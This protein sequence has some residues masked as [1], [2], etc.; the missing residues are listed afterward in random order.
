MKRVKIKDCE[1]LESS[2][3]RPKGYVSSLRELAT[4]EDDTQFWFDY[5]TYST[6]WTLYQKTPIRVQKPRPLDPKNPG[7]A[8]ALLFK[9]L[10]VK[11]R[12]DCGCEAMRR[13]MNRWGWRG[14]LT[15]LP[16]LV[17]HFK[18]QIPTFGTNE[19]LAW[20]SSGGK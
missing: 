18:K 20:L 3:K 15:H 6:L 5:A 12:K 16:E 11:P 17:R 19:V 8:A 9:S 4:K 14:C 7:D 13:K 1:T 2:G 10:G